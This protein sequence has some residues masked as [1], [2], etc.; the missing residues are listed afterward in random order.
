MREKESNKANVRRAEVRDREVQ[1]RGGDDNNR[2][3]DKRNVH[4]SGRSLKQ[5]N[6]IW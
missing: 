6:T 1:E 2:I 4:E 5:N 3:K